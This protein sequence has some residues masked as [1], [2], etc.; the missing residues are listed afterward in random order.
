MGTF[1]VKIATPSAPV[2]AATWPRNVPPS[3]FPVGS[4]GEL[5][6]NWIVKTEFGVLASI[7]ERIVELI[8]VATSVTVGAAWSRFGLA[9]AEA[10]RSIPSPRLAKIELVR[11]ALPTLSS[12]I[13]TPSLRLNAIVSP[14][15]TIPPP[16]TF[17]EAPW[18]MNTPSSSLPSA[19]RPVMSVPMKLPCTRLPVARAPLIRTPQ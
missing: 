9:S 15:A 16:I 3:F 10:T 8:E 18:P 5:T 2:I 6:K 1:A 19:A 17:W 11:M 12:S 4:N 14:A 13:R 7:P